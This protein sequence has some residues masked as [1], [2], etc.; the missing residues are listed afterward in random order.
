MA[1]RQ[2]TLS[3]GGALR[4]DERLPILPLDH[5]ALNMVEGRILAHGEEDN[6]RSYVMLESTD[7]KVYAI[8]QTKHMQEMRS[9]GG[10]RV[11][12]FVRLQR[13]HVEGRVR[14]EVEE[15]GTAESILK[16]RN[17][18]RQTAQ[19]LT[20]KRITPT[21]DGW[22]GWLGRYQQAVKRA[23]DSFCRGRGAAH[24]CR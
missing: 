9:A 22:G 6:G 7:A 14:I 18:L 19:R 3:A 11:N 13:V 12:T 23:A 10:L 21:E 15:L 24:R 2:K 4:S 1:D 20:R 16:D 8:T 5:R 17:Y